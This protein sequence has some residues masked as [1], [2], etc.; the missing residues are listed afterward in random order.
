[1]S[2]DTKGVFVSELIN[3]NVSVDPDD[4]RCIVGDGSE[5]QFF[6][7]DGSKI[8]VKHRISNPLLRAHSN[9][10][11]ETKSKK[12]QRESDIELQGDVLTVWVPHPSAKVRKIE[13]VFNDE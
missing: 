5:T 3:F 4:I 10:L 8:G 12:R 2:S 7:K 1:M 13:L 9:Y 6:M 11:N